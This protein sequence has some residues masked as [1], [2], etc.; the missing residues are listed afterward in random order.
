[1]PD[2]TLALPVS[3]AGEL[4]ARTAAHPAGRRARPGRSQSYWWHRTPPS[5]P[6]ALLGL[7]SPGLGGDENQS[8]F[9]RSGRKRD[10]GPSMVVQA[11]S[12]V[13]RWLTTGDSAGTRHCA[14]HA[15]E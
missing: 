7:P 1:M 12:A 13:G 4:Q 9:Q 2:V 15:L 11:A 14:S 3:D 5:Q 6:A 10:T 8:P